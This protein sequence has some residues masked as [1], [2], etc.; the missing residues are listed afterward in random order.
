MAQKEWT[1]N[2]PN[3]P[4][5]PFLWPENTLNGKQGRFD[6]TLNFQMVKNLSAMQE[7]QIPSLGW[8]PLEKEITTHSSILA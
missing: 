8:E 2:E 1:K 7:T 4:F 6:D 3:I 5:F